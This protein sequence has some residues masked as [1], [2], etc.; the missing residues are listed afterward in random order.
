M[1]DSAAH[2]S[3]SLK[4]FVQSEFKAY[5]DAYEELD[6]FADDLEDF[7]R[8]FLERELRDPMVN[9]RV[10]A[11]VKSWESTERKLEESALHVLQIPDLV[12]LRLVVLFREDIS[13]VDE[14]LDRILSESPPPGRL[15]QHWN[16]EIGR[17]TGYSS[18]HRQDRLAVDP[19]DGDTAS[20]V[21]PEILPS[22]EVQI[23]TELEDSWAV[24][25]HSNFYKNKDGIPHDTQLRLKRLAASLNLLDSELQS[26]KNQVEPE[27]KEIKKKITRNS[28]EW[29]G[30]TIDEATLKRCGEFPMASSFKALRK[31]GR[32]CGLRKSDWALLVYVGDE[33]DVFL[34]LVGRTRY[35]TLADLNDIVALAQS[36]KSE[37]T[38][39]VAAAK[40]AFDYRN[41]RFTM[42]DRPL[43][44]LT[45]ALL[46]QS[47]GLIETSLLRREIKDA[48]ALIALNGVGQ[49]T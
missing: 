30:L 23:R 44:V 25:T 32:E 24:L 6:R 33:T 40:I 1:S 20:L 27:L 37:I 31:L 45:I 9:V 28:T 47:P 2:A 46:L 22:F 13:A 5:E 48:I 14:I 11:R 18:L 34:S 38:D 39:V 19:H 26:I 29:H 8:T 43:L 7:V 41:Q 17:S 15:R 16:D 10:A 21:Q 3:R 35:R 42:F 12:G 49:D 36:R 4:E